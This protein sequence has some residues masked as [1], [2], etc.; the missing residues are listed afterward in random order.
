MRRNR[1][2]TRHTRSAC[3]S[4]RRAACATLHT[5]WAM[6]RNTRVTAPRS[7][8]ACS[9]SPTSASICTIIPHGT[10]PAAFIPNSAS[11]LANHSRRKITIKWL[12][13]LQRR[14]STPSTRCCVRRCRT[15]RYASSATRRASTPSE[16]SPNASALPARA[17]TLQPH[18]S[19]RSSSRVHCCAG[20]FSG[21]TRRPLT[22]RSYR[23]RFGGRL[24]Q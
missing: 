7:P 22:Q 4:R 14:A 24:S 23:Q 18:A 10:V 3:T 8:R 5:S 15:P 12:R 20:F 9:R 6:I 11:R 16:H 17:T 2:C 21:T 13:S 19:H 1:T